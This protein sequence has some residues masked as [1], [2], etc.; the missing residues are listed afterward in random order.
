MHW[1][2]TLEDDLPQA[3]LSFANELADMQ[4]YMLSKSLQRLTLNSLWTLKGIAWLMLSQIQRNEPWQKHLLNFDKFANEWRA[5][6]RNRS[7]KFSPA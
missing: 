1:G 2:A 3:V 6:K 7:M 5:G 4:L